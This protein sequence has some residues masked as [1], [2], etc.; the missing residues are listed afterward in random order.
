MYILLW[1]GER[2]YL[3]FRVFRCLLFIVPAC[4]EAIMLLIFIWM[5]NHSVL[6]CLLLKN[7]SNHSIS[8]WDGEYGTRFAPS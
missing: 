6:I 1:Q 4:L 2:Y 3:V 5:I 8:I 7:K